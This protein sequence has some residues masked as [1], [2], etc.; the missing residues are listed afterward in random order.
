M[1]HRAETEVEAEVEV[2]VEGEEAAPSAD[3]RVAISGAGRPV[4]RCSTS[5]NVAR[6]RRR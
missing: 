3:R 2:E 6:F 5:L 1:N 4:M